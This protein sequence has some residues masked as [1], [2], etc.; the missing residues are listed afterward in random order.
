MSRE[1]CPEGNFNKNGAGQLMWTIGVAGRPF[2]RIQVAR[3]QKRGICGAS[4]H[5]WHR[6]MV[7]DANADSMRH[8]GKN[9]NRDAA[10]TSDED[11]HLYFIERVAREADLDYDKCEAIY[12]G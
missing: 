5:E 12:A 10:G 2:V 6:K 8:N 7:V 9:L 1:Y 4:H 11:I 3:P